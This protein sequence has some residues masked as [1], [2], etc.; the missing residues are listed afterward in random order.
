MLENESL[1]RLSAFIGSLLFM[2]CWQWLAPRRSTK[3]NVWLRTFNNLGL[4]AV[5]WFIIRFLI[6]FI[7]VSNIALIIEQ[8]KWG[9]FQQISLPLSAV[10]IL[11]FIILDFTIYWQHRLFHKHPL[12]WKL[13]RVHH[14]DKDLD[15]SSGVRF[16]P[17]EII[18]SILVKSLVVVLFGIPV[19]AVLIFEVILNV[20]PIFNHSNVFIPES[21]DK[22]LRKF[23]VTP[24]M[25]RIHHSTIKHETNS[26][27]CFSISLW[28]Y[29]FNTYTDKPHN[30]Q[31]KMILGLNEIPQS[32]SVLL[33]TLLQQ[34]FKRYLKVREV[35]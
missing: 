7:A 18:L 23:I 1:I 29:I 16:H 9:L 12:L 31:T 26:N 35:K 4:I 15:A 5:S 6:P 2:Y 33:T 25:H 3:I 8:Y 13:H 20:L 28:D 24:D 11:S 17:I 34:P 19:I 22:H 14:S 30:G 10:I 27:Y 21:V 32:D